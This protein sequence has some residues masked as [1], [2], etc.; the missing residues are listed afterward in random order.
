M[1]TDIIIIG[2]G[3]GGYEVAVRAAKQGRRV[4]L[5]E[6]RA[7][8]GTCLNE[9]CIPT[10]CLCHSA[11]VL[12]QISEG[13]SL[14]ITCESV[15]FDLHQAIA[16]K[17][18]VVGRLSSGIDMLLRH[19]NISVVQGSARF[20]D[21]HTIAVAA[22]DGGSAEETLYTAPHIIIATG[23]V[24]KRLPIPGADSAGVV[25]S[26]EM[27]RLEQL[28]QRLCVIGGGVIGLEF[29]SIFR[30]FGSEV[31][32]VE[33]CKEVL[34]Q[35]DK[36]I[37]KRLRTALKKRGI[38]FHTGAAVTAIEHLESGT[39]LVSYE[40][41]G[42]TESLEADLVLMAVGRAPYFEGLGLSEVGINHT[43]RG[44]VVDENM[45][46]N[47]PG[48]YAV[49]DVNGLCQLAHA[50]TF[51]SY[52]AL[53]HIMERPSPTR[54]DI[55]P[56][57]VF[58]S[59]EAATVGL[60]EEALTA[61]GIAYTTHKSFYRAN[62]RALTAGAEE[63]LVKLLADPNDGRILGAHILG[64]HAAELIHEVSQLMNVDG[65]LSQI[66]HSVHAHPSM[67]ELILGAAGE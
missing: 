46:T 18:E 22:P 25:T 54:L 58:T 27:L 6:K 49:G 3:P 13:P 63:G 32:V 9:G 59:P 57:V 30:S 5:I 34:P 24:T 7:V 12:E 10:K 44:I 16:R 39:S 53:D 55:V 61:Q 36:D 19:P 50:A 17:D 29:A 28:P 60:S 41:K 45:Q 33:Y 11:E 47:V 67:S 20:V 52:R 42:R 64:A 35:F 23:S 15:A 2:A 38:V 62:G 48:V 65:T 4:V 1:E 14:G 8:G 26:T 56:A 66:S 40:E 21:G 51:Q 43:P 37:A 31:T